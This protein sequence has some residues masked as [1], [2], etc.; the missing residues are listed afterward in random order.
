MY[1]ARHL[2]IAPWRTALL[3]AALAPFGYYIA[4][5]LAASRFF[6]RDRR[7]LF[8]ESW[9]PVS[10]L[11]P[12]HGIDFASHENL[13]SFCTLDYPE[14]E[15]LFAVNDVS[16]PAVPV[17]ERIMREHPERRMRL[18]VGAP[19]LGVNRKVNSLARMAGEAAHEV[20]VLTDGDVRVGANFLRET[21]APLAT[22]RAELV[23]CLYRGVAQRS[24][25]AELEALGAA[26]DFLPGAIVAASSGR[27]SFALGAAIAT[28]KAQLARIGG[29]AAIANF[30][31]DDY[32]LGHRTA[33]RGGRAVLCREP[34]W[35]MYPAQT[36]R[37]FWE[38]QVRWAR[39]VRICQPAPYF[40]LVL[41]L[42]L[43]W[44]LLVYALAPSRVVGTAYVAAYLILRFAMAWTVG[45]WGLRD[46]TTRQKWWLIPLRDAMHF[47][48]WLA[49]LFSN[50]V[51]WG[52]VEYVVE[53]GEMRR[54]SEAAPAN[55]ARP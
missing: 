50:R 33:Q 39:T 22:A 20:L 13:A 53:R 6:R 42:G 10:I 40:G 55:P 47:F 23:S 36:L 35:T 12:L 38:H 17:V 25:P 43:P 24:L 11:K 32:E 30:L 1:L 41:T 14:Y 7:G 37:G 48:V 46:E 52:G 27:V 19:P 34:V 28:T 16:D 31:A 51:V 5:M 9:P 21:V 26:T 15:I 4:A 8:P 45:V 44:T 29:F 3:V 18:L 49:G 54:V 2:A